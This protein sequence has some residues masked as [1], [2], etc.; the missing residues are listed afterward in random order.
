MINYDLPWN[1]MRIEQ[2]I[3]R[4][5]RNGQTSESVSIYNMITP[6]TVDADIYNRCLYR[7]GVF[8]NSIG[9]CEEILGEITGEIRKLAENFQITV[10]ERQEKL[11]Q[12]TDNKIRY[13]KEREELEDKQRDLFG[14]RV[15]ENAFDKELENATNYWLSADKIQNLVGCYLNERLGEEKEYILGEKLTKTL[16]LSQTAREKLL[17][18][19]K[20][21]KMSKN[22]ISRSWEK[23]LKSGEQHLTISFDSDTCKENKN[24][25]FISIA[26]PLIKQ[27]AQF[28][29]CDNKSVTVLNVKTD[30]LKAGRYPFAVYQW[31][32]LGEHE[33]LVLK[34][35]AG[36]KDVND[37]I[38]EL[39]KA[40]T[41]SNEEIEFDDKIWE[42][43]EK[44][45]YKIWQKELEEHKNKTNELIRYK[46]ASLT[47][48][49]N[50][51]IEI[52]KEQLEKSV[53]K[54]YQTMTEGKLRAANEDY[55][56]HMKALKEAKE[57]ADILM[58][59][60]SYGVL[61][62]EEK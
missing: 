40:S 23:W 48:G 35:V 26:H 11:Q 60:L 13:I 49:H 10:E 9:D 33:D 17:Y 25:T 45:H 4:I 6:G 38:I 37:I 43:V 15:P 59:L 27:A 3:G 21:L 61:I 52:I 47:T 7:I 24:I 22:K 39:L 32:Y 56:R 62:V 29:N 18:D 14:I 20:K 2:R 55:D 12:M 28:L 41:T 57:K 5:D 54:N 16:R 1:P 30:K 8:H 34:P 42:D 31:H 19:Y 46:E 51:R 58:E 44:I 53:N 36:E 50:A